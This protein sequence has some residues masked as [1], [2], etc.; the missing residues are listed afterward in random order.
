MAKMITVK[1]KSTH[2]DGFRRI[3]RLWPR[4][5]TIATVTEEEFLVLKA[6]PKLLVIEVPDAPAKVAEA[7][8]APDAAAK[9]DTTA[10]VP[11]APA[12]AK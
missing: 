10:K 6:E 9:T 12:K 5:E 4:A 1:V 11:D 8:K 2:A 7:P 3:G